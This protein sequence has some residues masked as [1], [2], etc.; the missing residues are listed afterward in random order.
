MPTEYASSGFQFDYS[1]TSAVTSNGIGQSLYWPQQPISL[2]DAGLE[3]RELSPLVLKFLFMHGWHSG[4][5]ISRQL[6]LPFPLIE[7]ILQSMRADQLI[8]HKTSAPGNDYVYEISPKGSEQARLAIEQSTYC[9][10]APVSIEQYANAVTRQSLRNF[11][12]KIQNVIDAL[13]DLVVS[14]LLI[15]Q[16][17]QAVNSGKSMLLYGP[18]GNGK[19][20][21]AQRLLLSAES[22]MWIPR[23]LAVG[24]EVIRVFDPA[25]HRESPLKEDHSL[26]RS[27]QIDQRW[28]R[29]QR[30]IIT[31]GGE[32]RMDHLEATFNPVTRII[33]A[34]IH[35]KSNGGCLIVDDFG[36]QE[37]SMIELLNRWIVPMDSGGDFINLPSGRQIKLPFDQLLIY[38]TNL[39]PQHVCD[40]AFLRRIPYKIEIFDPTEQQFRNLFELRS[41][42]FG[43]D[44]QPGILDYLIEYHFKRTNRQLRFCFVE[45][46]L[47]QAKDYCNFHEKPLVFN[48]DIAEMA[49]LNYF[50]R[51]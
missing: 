43:F 8:A 40:E 29:I 19:T 38:S 44:L 3:T 46:L 41:Q 10:S 1:T 18:T 30:P 31:V 26:A 24:I 34:P 2:A 14:K 47:N 42:Q 21:I 15:G 50:S 33:E 36:R 45:D 7:P 16:L 20:S 9:G 39:T 11:K 27:Q 22:T 5:V 12:I 48:R 49:V 17:G 6:K 37:I 25:V 35:I 23:A 32:L 13:G 51:L 4:A 28:V